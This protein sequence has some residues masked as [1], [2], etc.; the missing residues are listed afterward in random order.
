MTNKV[1]DNVKMDK[2]QAVLISCLSWEQLMI[3]YSWACKIIN[4]KNIQDEL[5]ATCITLNNHKGFKSSPKRNNYV[6][7]STRV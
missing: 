4:N 1:D 3:S 5:F 7:H 2:I 6:V